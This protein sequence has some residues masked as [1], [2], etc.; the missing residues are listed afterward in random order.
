MIWIALNDEGRWIL[1]ITSPSE[2]GITCFHTPI[3]EL[4]N[5]IQI[6]GQMPSRFYVILYD[7]I[8]SANILISL[9]L[10]YNVTLIWL[11]AGSF[12]RWWLLWS[13]ELRAR[14]A[15]ARASISIVARSSKHMTDI[16]PKWKMKSWTVT[17][18]IMWLVCEH[19]VEKSKDWVFVAHFIHLFNTMIPKPNTDYTPEPWCHTS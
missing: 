19:G 12:V 8:L 15:V 13:F 11:P 4:C 5:A 16:M 14:A 10:I 6:T 18:V 9:K 7:V 17:R 3:P 2:W 1:I